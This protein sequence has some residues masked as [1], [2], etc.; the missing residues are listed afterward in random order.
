MNPDP[1]PPAQCEPIT[2]CPIIVTWEQ[3]PTP[4]GPHGV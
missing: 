1:T 2:S 3:R 4:M